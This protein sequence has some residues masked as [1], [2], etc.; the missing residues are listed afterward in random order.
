MRGWP[1]TTLHSTQDARMAVY[2]STLYTRCEDGE[3]LFSLSPR[4]L[5]SFLKITPEAEVRF[6][7]DGGWGRVMENLHTGERGFDPLRW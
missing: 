2:N 1:S 3:K 7:P 6:P 4:L 5:L